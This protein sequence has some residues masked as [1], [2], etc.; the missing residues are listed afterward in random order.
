MPVYKRDV[1]SLAKEGSAKLKGD[2]TLS[3]GSNVTL[4]QSGNDI[5]IASS[6]GAS[7]ATTALDNLASVAINTSLISD[8]DDTDDLGS[9]TKEWK[10]LYVDG[11]AYLDA[12][13]L[14]GTLLTATGAELNYVDGVTS[15][16]Q[17][18][19]DAKAPIASPTFT[20]TVTLP[21]GLTGVIRADSGVV[22]TDSDV[23]DL[24]SAA[25]DTAAGKV[26]LATTAETTTGTDA[27]RAVTPDGLHDMTS[28]AG[29]VWFLDEDDMAS[30]SATKT[31]SQQSIKAYVDAG[32][33]G[34]A[35][36]AL[37]NLASVAINAALVLGTSDAF[38]LGSATKQW[39][40]LYLAE[41]GVINWDN[42][43][44][45][46]TQTGNAVALAGAT[47]GVTGANGTLSL[48]A[49]TDGGEFNLYSS[50]SGTLAI[51]GAAGETLNVNMLDGSL[52]VATIEL[53]HAT[54]TT[55][56]RSAAGQVTIEGNV[57]Y[58]AGGTDVPVADGGTG[59]SSASDARTALGLAIGSDVQAYDAELAA[60]AG[61]TSAANKL[62][63]FTGS[64]T[65]AVADFIPGAWTSWTPTLS[66]RLNDAKWTKDCK[67]MRIGKSVFFRFSITASTTTPMDGGSVGAIFTLP[68]TSVDYAPGSVNVYGITTF[69]GLYDAGTATLVGAAT[70]GSTTTAIIKM[71]PGTDPAYTNLTSTTPFTWTTN[72][73]IY[74]EGFYEAA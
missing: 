45:T 10:D 37:D 49:D 35:T 6:G 39:S 69:G 11:T 3:E 43:D 44:A 29:A 17:T 65:A 41:G 66:G 73:A 18:Q 7:G 21:V 36:T 15:A 30:N 61:L 26:E 60:L 50:A 28:L 74:L 47:F 33:G 1:S 31:A 51:F 68:L 25:S 71:L 20:G 52:Q 23:T 40:D 48:S 4:T 46:L 67:Y 63:Y 27:T 2:V 58:R 24:V 8:T 59:S 57:I 34:G 56:A 19:L 16:I 54:D 42:G 70:W 53:G 38:A 5:E 55:L 22:S 72:D 64:G 13:D 12:I 14:N 32:G 62:P 9:A